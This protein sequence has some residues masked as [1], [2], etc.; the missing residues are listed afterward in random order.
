MCECGCFFPLVIV[1]ALSY[2]SKIEFGAHTHITV[3]SSSAARALASLH[4]AVLL[5]RVEEQPVWL[6]CAKVQRDRILA[7]DDWF[8]ARLA[9]VVG[10]ELGA[11]ERGLGRCFVCQ[12]A[13]ERA[14][15]HVR[16]MGGNI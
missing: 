11:A 12:C 8:A 6:A 5:T 1:V 13:S 14:R 15:V 2:I 9:Q 16:D 10:E 3:V 7:A 4:C